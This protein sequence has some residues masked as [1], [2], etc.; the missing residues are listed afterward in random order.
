MNRFFTTVFMLFGLVAVAH[1]QSD[2]PFDYEKVAGAF[3]QMKAT[4]GFDTSKPLQW[5]FFFI[6]TK[7]APLL[8]IG[9]I[10]QSSGYQYVEEHQD[11][12]GK[13][14]LQ[15]AKIE[16]HTSKSLHIRNGEL[17]LFTKK[18]PGVVYDGW[19]VT[20]QP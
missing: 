17:L 18:Y 3:E 2:S 12:N 9:K 13:F 20:R 19:D 11:E 5:G 4:P 1:A 8:E 15:L 10:L 6:S 16:V 7:R 14:W